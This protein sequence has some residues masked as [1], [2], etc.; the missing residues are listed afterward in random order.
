MP[1]QKIRLKAVRPFDYKENPD[2]LGEH[3]KRRR[4]QLGQ[5]QR[6]AA[7]AIQCGSWTWIG[8]EKHGVEPAVRFIPH[9]IDWLGYDPFP[10]GKI[11]AEQLTW[12][13]KKAGLTRAAFAELLGLNYST[14]EQ[15]EH[16]VC[17]P[18]DDNLAKV[19]LV[20]KLSTGIAN[21][22]E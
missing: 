10:E 22:V 18:N 9:I 12:R 17:R 5:R 14:V 15:W 4:I 7:E 3:L 13:R 1:F 21:D 2:A 20:L 6:D 11:F 19:S 8:W 16:G